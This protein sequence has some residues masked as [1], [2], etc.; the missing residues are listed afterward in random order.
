MSRDVGRWSLETQDKSTLVAFAPGRISLSTP[1]APRSEGEFSSELRY[2]RSGRGRNHNQPSVCSLRH[3]EDVDVWVVGVVRKGLFRI[4]SAAVQ[5][6]GEAPR[7][8]RVGT[9]TGAAPQVLEL[10]LDRLADQEE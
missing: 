6:L 5:I 10:A 8:R 9:P 7:H 3:P 1:P 4:G 2:E